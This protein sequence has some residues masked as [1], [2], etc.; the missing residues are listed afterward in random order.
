MRTL[1]ISAKYHRD[2]TWSEFLEP[3]AAGLETEAAAH[4]GL[5]ILLRN[6]CK[7]NLSLLSIEILIQDYL[8]VCI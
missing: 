1:G 6:V 8:N 5:V 4:V 2:W 7:F 3:A